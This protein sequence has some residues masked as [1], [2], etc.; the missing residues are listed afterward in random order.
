M[1]CEEGVA[2]GF[3]SHRK[4]NVTRKHDNH[5]HITWVCVVCSSSSFFYHASH[6]VCVCVC[7]C[8]CMT[9]IEEARAV[10]TGRAV[11]ADNSGDVVVNFSTCAVRSY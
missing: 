3:V 9:I 10:V 4:W 8:V 5:M 7:V 6:R 1:R 2:S 11:R